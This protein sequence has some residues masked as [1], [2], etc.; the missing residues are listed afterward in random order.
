MNEAQLGVV[1]VTA[2]DQAVAEKI[3]HS[4]LEKKL[5]ACVNI[6]PGL[7]SLY[8]WEGSVEKDQEL[9]LIIKTRLALF[10]DLKDQVLLDHPYQNPEVIALPIETGADPYLKWIE[11]ETG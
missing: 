4:L 7:I 1:L 5:A 3:S 10:E 11:S 2:P 8:R 9:L 6:I